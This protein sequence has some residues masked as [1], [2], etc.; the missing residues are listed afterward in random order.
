MQIF[1]H[2]IGWLGAAIMVSSLPI[3]FFE[4]DN[5]SQLGMSLFVGACIFI[6]GLI[7][8][9]VA[10]FFSKW[11]WWFIVALV[12]AIA[13]IILAVLGL[14]HDEL[15]DYGRCIGSDR[16]YSITYSSWVFYL[17]PGLAC[18]IWGIFT[19]I[20]NRVQRSRFLWLGYII[21]GIILDIPLVLYSL[22]DPDYRFV[23]PWLLPGLVLIIEGIILKIRE[24]RIDQVIAA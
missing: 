3:V 19:F 21:C 17:I 7:L 1:L 20:R 10:G 11:R 8:L 18:I 12:I 16:V 5:I 24:Q 13:Y 9:S 4:L 6:P 23:I 14:I 15:L 22:P 2:V